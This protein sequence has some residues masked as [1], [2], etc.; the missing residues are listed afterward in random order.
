MLYIK[1]IG[2][3]ACLLH[4]LQAPAAF[5]QR[6]PGEVDSSLLPAQYAHYQPEYTLDAPVNK[7]AWL[8]QKSGLHV[9]FVST[10]RAWFRTEAPDQKDAVLW[11]AAGWRGER[12]NTE[13]LIWSPDTLE[14]VRVNLA[15]LVN[16]K[17]NA[18]PKFKQILF[19]WPMCR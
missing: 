18:I 2:A 11:E 16:E 5:A 8:D 3:I 1:R 7:Q 9:S 6:T 14:Q 13:I 17:G 12:L 19:A 4:L 15:N 10:D